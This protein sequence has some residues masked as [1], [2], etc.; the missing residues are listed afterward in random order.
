MD[1]WLWGHSGRLT[2]DRSSQEVTQLGSQQVLPKYLSVT[3]ERN[4]EEELSTHLGYTVIW[5]FLRPHLVIHCVLKAAL[6]F[7]F[8]LC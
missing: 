8:I 2:H 1:Q 3:V 7:R 6:N 5:I 4:E